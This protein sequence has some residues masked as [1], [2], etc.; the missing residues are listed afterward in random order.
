MAGGKAKANL[1]AAWVEEARQRLA[2]MVVVDLGLYEEVLSDK[3]LQ[4]DA[5]QFLSGGCHC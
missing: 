1:E 4:Y 3:C 5:G 2:D